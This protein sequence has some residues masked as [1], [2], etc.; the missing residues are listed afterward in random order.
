MK[1]GAERRRYPR[2][3][4]NL[5]AY[6]RAV[7]A[8]PAEPTLAGQTMDVCNGGLRLMMPDLAGL[9]VADEITITI[10]PDQY[11]NKFELAGVIRWIKTDVNH[12]NEYEVGISL[13]GP[14]MAKWAIF[15]AS[16]REANKLRPTV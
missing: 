1:T 5:P 2:Y 8:R 4:I 13:V 15:L 12:S 3:S 10:E 11:T 9:Q 7:E 14:E 6:T 16:L